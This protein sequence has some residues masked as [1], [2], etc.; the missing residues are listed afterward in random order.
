MF[1]QSVSSLEKVFWDTKP[2]QLPAF[3]GG[4]ML[5]GER[6]S[7]QAVYG[8][9]EGAPDRLIATCSV[10]CAVKGTL[11]VARVC[12][13]PVMMPVSDDRDED[14]LRTTPGLYPDVILPIHAESVIPIMAGQVGALWFD[15][16]PDEDCPA[17]TYP[18][19]I[20]LTDEKGETCSCSVE[21][22][23]IAAQLPEQTL[24]YTQWFYCD[25]LANYYHVPV[26]SEEHWRILENHL[27]TARSGGINMIL[28][29]ILTP[30]LDTQIGGERLTV[31]LVDVKRMG[32][33]YTFGFDKLRRWID[34]CRKV[35]IDRFEMAHMF[36]QWGAA[37]APKV[38][39]QTEE[40][41][42]RIFGWDTEATDPEYVRFLRTLIPQV[43]AVLREKGIDQ[44]HACFHISDEP[45]TK[46]LEAYTAARRS[47]EDLLEG[48]P[49]MDAMSD[50]EFYVNG[51]V[52]CPVPG[53]RHIAPFLEHEV[54]GLWAYYCS[55][56]RRKVSN[57][58]LSMSSSRNRILGMQL[59]RWHIEGFLHWGYNFYNT[60]L[61]RT[62]LQPFL[63][64]DGDCMCEAGDQFS[65]YPAQDGTAL[66][67]LRF[68]V[69]AHALQ[70]MRA[71][72]LCEKLCGWD[73]VCRVMDSHGKLTFENSS[74]GAEALLGMREE[75]N[76]LIAENL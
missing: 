15:M 8:A 36:T 66:E 20:T 51:V 42:K 19:T 2:E 44:K 34:L 7:F 54:P 35:G 68:V 61:S 29:P 76:R 14:Y 21:L 30:A 65:V 52:E 50:Y 69:F 37:H 3:R 32:G 62:T 26:F 17:G 47:I 6:Y 74:M 67:S 45:R 39:A 28:T 63:M 18:V 70:D 64:T 60:G 46:S 73:A 49:I 41:E 9:S 38:V 58:F 56:G 12:N 33:E 11:S 10:E 43:I 16:T 55:S 72:A 25:C 59:Y 48:Y 1:I 75:I 27:R 71:L 40:G 23:V 13:V 22:T 53:T 31:Q 5:R 4:S 57:R 24:I